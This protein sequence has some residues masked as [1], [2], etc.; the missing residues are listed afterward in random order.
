MPAAEL[1]MRGSET[2]IGSIC[3]RRKH[4]LKYMKFIDNAPHNRYIVS[5][6]HA[7]IQNHTY[8]L[9]QKNSDGISNFWER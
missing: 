1:R 4:D 5:E 6:P 7:S 8:W 9:A 3:R 2:L